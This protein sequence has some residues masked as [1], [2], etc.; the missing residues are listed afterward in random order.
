M[1]IGVALCFRQAPLIAFA[2]L[3]SAAN[4][5]GSNFTG[6]EAWAYFNCQVLW[7]WRWT[8]FPGTAE[9]ND[10]VTRDP[11]TLVNLPGEAGG[12]QRI[13]LRIQLYLDGDIFL[14]NP[15]IR[16]IVFQPT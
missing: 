10:P 2:S 8:G 12:S 14:N 16:W 3:G 9:P 4:A 13:M 11:N 7:G 1:A 6:N 5:S 15:T